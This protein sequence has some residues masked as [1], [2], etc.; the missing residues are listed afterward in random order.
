MVIWSGGSI[1]PLILAL[2]GG[3]GTGFN[4]TDVV[5]T[6]IRNYGSHPHEIKRSMRNN[7][8]AMPELHDSRFAVKSDVLS[9]TEIFSGNFWLY[10][11]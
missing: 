2:R 10:I 6:E 8:A 5:G 1:A 7:S 11:K 9:Q 3:W 4:S